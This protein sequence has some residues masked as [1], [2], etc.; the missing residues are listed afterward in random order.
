MLQ[1]VVQYPRD[2]CVD[3]ILWWGSV[4]LVRFGKGSA[5]AETLKKTAKSCS[6]N[7]PIPTNHN[8]RTAGGPATTGTASAWPASNP[9]NVL[10]SSKLEGKMKLRV[11]TDEVCLGN[12]VA[13]RPWLLPK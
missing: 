13:Q 8:V 7:Q 4:E 11:K 1:P 3:T 5:V 12:K 6:R 2:P 10:F 9:Q